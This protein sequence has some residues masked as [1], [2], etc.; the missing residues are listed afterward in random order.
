MW[1]NKGGQL[2]Q[3]EITWHNKFWLAK[4]KIVATLALGSRLRQKLARLRPKRETKKSYLMLPGM[5]KS[6]RE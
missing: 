1:G 6:V 5:Q 4:G 2:I 3:N